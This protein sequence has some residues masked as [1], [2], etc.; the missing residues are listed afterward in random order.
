MTRAICTGHPRQSRWPLPLII[1]GLAFWLLAIA[2]GQSDNFTWSQV[3]EASPEALLKLL[4]DKEVQVRRDAVFEVL[5]RSDYTPAVVVA[6]GKSTADDDT[7][8][9]VQSLT[10]LARAG[11]LAEPA[12]SEILARMSDR[13]AQVR[14]RS[15]CAL[16]AIGITAI[17]PL[18]SNWS[19]AGTDSRIAIAQSLALIGSPAEAA[20]PLLIEAL[21]DSNGLPRYAAEALAAIAPQ[22]EAMLLAL[23]EH[24]DAL[25]RSVGL[26]GLAALSAPSEPVMKKL[27]QAVS[28]S[29]V[30]IR[31]SAIVVV[32]KSKLPPAE[33]APLIEAAL[34]DS[35]PAVRA[36]ALVALRKASLPAEEFARQIVGKLDRVEAASA[37]SLIKA[38]AQLGPQARIAFPHVVAVASKADIDSHQV[39]L[40]LASFGAEVV[41]E[42]LAAVER[43]PG[44]EPVFSQALA[45]IGE[46]AVA[47][48]LTGLTSPADVV[49]AASVRALGGVRPTHRSLLEKVCESIKDPSSPVRRIAIE[50]LIA[51]HKEADFAKDAI[52]ASANDVDPEVRAAALRSLVSFRYADEQAIAAIER[53]LGDASPAVRSGTLEVLNEE[54]RL[55]QT[56]GAQLAGMMRDDDAGVRAKVA[57]ALGK[58]DKQKVDEATTSALATGLTDDD[59]MVRE[60]ATDSV[61][62]LGV[63]NP[64]LLSA[65]GANL[66][67]DLP[68]MLATLN[69]L[70]SCGEKAAAMIPEIA[71]LTTQEKP[72]VRVGALNAMAAIEKDHVML[73]GRL[74]D[75]LEDKAWEVR[76]VAGVALGK[77]GPD[78]KQ[79]VPKLFQLL[80]SDEDR[81]FASSTLKEINT[82]PVEAIP[83]LIE[84]LDSEERRTSFYAVSLLGK[85]GPPAAE[86]LPKLEAMLAKPGGEPGRAEF[87]RKFLVEAIAAIK[88]EP[89]PE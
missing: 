47:A 61:K 88:G 28:D 23:A 24:P 10:G 20:R 57:I 7:Q 84:K 54:P 41:P 74:T 4:E 13:D 38:L 21:G 45:W 77:L 11:K 85:I 26:T 71:R 78:A 32:G 58:L 67:E 49:R 55:L 59:R 17:E 31:E 86:A 34:T 9:R 33:K 50:A 16:G 46:P 14:Y 2:C 30:K 83:L 62:G 70:A 8:V 1:R 12:M 18:M 65:L 6:L 52:L 25:A 19:S 27:K 22:D 39:S 80:S 60:A 79:A 82:A 64:E 87:R 35:A 53:G 63:C 5:R 3:R 40:T 43:Q 29:D 68:L 72:E 37:N 89:K 42:L 69:A 44:S 75:A 73:S 36:A 51:N 56:R 76:R 66:K 15:A 48:L 81:D